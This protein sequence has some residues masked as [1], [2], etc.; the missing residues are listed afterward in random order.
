MSHWRQQDD[1]NDPEYET[2]FDELA[3]NLKVI[4][5][6]VN[7]ATQGCPL[8]AVIGEIGVAVDSALELM[9]FVQGAP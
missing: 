6:A 4:D 2:S 9:P 5:D 3:M 7:M 1:P 8:D